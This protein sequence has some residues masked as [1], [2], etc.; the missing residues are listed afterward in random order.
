[1]RRLLVSCVTVLGLVG[2]S[3][4]PSN[5]DGQACVEIQQLAS[6]KGNHTAQMRQVMERLGSERIRDAAR[7]YIED[8]NAET[9]RAF[10]EACATA[11]STT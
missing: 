5:Y 6:R 1:M 2:C 4:G 8:R 10:R 9:S 11:S 7:D 3:G